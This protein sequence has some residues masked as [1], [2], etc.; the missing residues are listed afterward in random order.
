VS[1]PSNI[2]EGYGRTATIDCTGRVNI[3]YRSVFELEPQ[4]LQAG[5][6]VLIEEV[7]WVHQYKILQKLKEC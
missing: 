2:A 1:I 7:N 5:D 3:S 6:L 4:I